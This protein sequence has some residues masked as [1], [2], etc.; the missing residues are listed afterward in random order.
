W[1]KHIKPNAKAVVFPTSTEQV[2][3]LVL[4]ARKTKTSLVPSGG[5]TGMSGAAAAANQEVIVSLDKMNKILGHDPIDRTVTCQAG[6]VTEQLQNYALEN[7]FYYPVDFAAR[8][9]SQVGGNIATNAGGIKV[10]RYGLTRS[11][12]AGMTVV[13]GQGQILHLNNSLVKNATGYDLRHLFIGSEGTLGFVTEATFFVTNPPKS[14][15]VLLFGVENLEGVLNIYQAYRKQVPLTAYEMFTEEALVHVLKQGHLSRPLNETAPYYVLIE[16]ELE[17]DSTLDHAMNLFEECVEKGWVV[18]GAMSQSPQQA[19]EFWRLREDISEATAP[20]EP[21]KNDISVRVT[22]VT[23]FLTE[24][25]ALIKSEYPD[26]EVIWFG[27]IGDG[28]L[29]INILKPKALSSEEFLK[30]CHEVDKHMF[31][32][33]ARYKGSVSAEHGVGLT[34][35]PY[36]HYTRSHEEIQL[37]KDIKNIFDP[38]G[39]LNPGKLF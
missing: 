19:K 36:L 12:V 3:D 8:G 1:A 25:D 38:D 35:K 15:T 13:T 32:M 33:I 30:K 20:F 34:K 28:N 11:W 22:H 14:L 37:M 18:D 10:L 31:E 24:L 27:H 26:F 5:R 9:S 16:F 29:H 2:R 7:D 39:I 23:Q 6:V 17:S 4:W 21:Y